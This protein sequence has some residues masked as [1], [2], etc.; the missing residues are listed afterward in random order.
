MRYLPPI[1]IVG[2]LF[3]QPLLY[4]H[5]PGDVDLEFNLEEH[6]LTVRVQHHTEAPLVHYINKIVVE[7]NDNEMIVQRFKKQPTKN[8]QIAVYKMIDAKIDDVIQVTAYCNINGKKKETLVV[9]AVEEST[10]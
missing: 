1:L 7:L 8:I 3:L 9:N 6:L 4:A 5:P 10:N 2:L